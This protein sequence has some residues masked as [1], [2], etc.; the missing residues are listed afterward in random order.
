MEGRPKSDNDYV[1]ITH[2]VPYGKLNEGCG[3][4][5]LDKMLN[6]CKKGFHITRRTFASRLL[7]SKTNT[8]TIANL[9]G[10]SDSGTVLKY[11]STDENMMRQCALS[12]KGIEVKGGLLL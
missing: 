6:E 4:R 8:D 9:L 3:H 10:H 11:L 1:F 2:R 12:L 7:K 5:A